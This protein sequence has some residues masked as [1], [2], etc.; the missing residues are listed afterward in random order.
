VALIFEPFP[1]TQ[2]VFGRSQQA[3]LL[4]GVFATL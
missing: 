2:L 3:G 1:Q 4:L